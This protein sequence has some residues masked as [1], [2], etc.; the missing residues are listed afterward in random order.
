MYC[1]HKVAQIVQDTTVELCIW[2]IVVG[3]LIEKAG[4]AGLFIP[5]FGFVLSAGG[6]CA[7]HFSDQ[8]RPVIGH[9]MNVAHQPI[10]RDTDLVNGANAEISI[11]SGQ[12]RSRET[13][14]LHQRRLQQPAHHRRIGRQ[15]P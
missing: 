3:C 8:M 13:L 15:T 1:S 14:H 5:R 12:C 7:G 4:K 6:N 11:K 2:T 9:S 10:G